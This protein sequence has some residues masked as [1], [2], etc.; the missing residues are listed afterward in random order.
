[1]LNICNTLFILILENFRFKKLDPHKLCSLESDIKV[2]E[3]DLERHATEIAK[4]QNI[5][6]TKLETLE[7]GASLSM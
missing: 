2:I 3:Q 4:I 5:F 7:F 1:M 6:K